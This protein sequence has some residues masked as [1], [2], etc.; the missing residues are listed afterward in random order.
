MMTLGPQLRPRAAK[1]GYY[2]DNAGRTAA[3]MQAGNPMVSNAQ[4]TDF[5]QLLL[6]RQQALLDL[7]AT[8][9]AAAGVVELDQSSVGRLSRMDALQEQAMSQ[10]RLRRRQLEL[11]Q[12]AAALQRIESG[13]YGYCVSCGEDIAL[14]RLQHD[15]SIPLCI[16]CASAREQR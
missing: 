6:A 3:F 2:T 12:I 11:Q 8:G 9:E 13:D 10:E 1:G 7:Q 14:P 5:R 15:P 16:D 4:I